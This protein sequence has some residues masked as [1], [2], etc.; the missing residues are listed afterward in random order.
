V[1]VLERYHILLRLVKFTEV[2]AWPYDTK[3][4]WDVS[5]VAHVRI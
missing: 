5:L 3:S 1:S 2:N 4:E